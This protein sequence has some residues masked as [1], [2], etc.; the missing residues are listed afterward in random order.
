MR[1]LVEYIALLRPS[2][3]QT[4]LGDAT[5]EPQEKRNLPENRREG[6]RDPLTTVSCIEPLS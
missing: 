3:R 1:I 5:L 2:G 6:E 4:T